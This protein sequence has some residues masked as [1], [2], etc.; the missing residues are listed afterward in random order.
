MAF[1]VFGEFLFWVFVCIAVLLLVITVESY[2]KSEDSLQGELG[3]P[4]TIFLIVVGLIIYSNNPQGILQSFLNHW[5]KWLIYVLGYTMFG[6]LWS[7]FRWSKVVKRSYKKFKD[8]M[9][10][11]TN[12]AKRRIIHFLNS[13]IIPKKFGFCNDELIKLKLKI[14]MFF[15]YVIYFLIYVF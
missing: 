2:K 1:L 6:I 5:S 11:N 3:W 15:Y 7:F 14:W 12:T 10:N 13:V 4:T 9:A 8:Y